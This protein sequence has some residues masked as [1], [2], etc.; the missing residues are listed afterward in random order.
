MALVQ[1]EGVFMNAEI[2]TTTFEG[3]SKTNLYVEV[4]QKESPA[5][6]KL[7]QLKTE[8]L[9]LMKEITENYDFGSIVNLKATLTAYK[10]Q[11]YFKLLEFVS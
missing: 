3:N 11:T 9:S 7:V 2:K 10:N 1:L 5:K 8:D 4:Y 6:D